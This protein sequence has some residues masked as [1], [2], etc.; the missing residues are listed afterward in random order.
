MEDMS[1]EE[2]LEKLL[3]RS[4]YTGVGTVKR[5]I[6]VELGAIAQMA[7]FAVHTCDLDESEI[8]GLARRIDDWHQV[9]NRIEDE[10]ESDNIH[11]VLR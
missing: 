7:R 10:L 4:K 1:K 11:E 9:L 5:D 2:F 6:E 8:D 3:Y